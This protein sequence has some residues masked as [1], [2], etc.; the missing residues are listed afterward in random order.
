[1]QKASKAN[2]YHYNPKLKPY[3]RDNR[4]CMPKSAIRLWRHVLSNR[5]MLDYTFKRERPVL[6][7]I[8]DFMC[9]E[10]LLV[11]EVDGITHDDD[12]QHRRDQRRDKRLTEVG[13]RVVRYSSWEVLNDIDWVYQ[14]LRRIIDETVME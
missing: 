2:N 13:F 10:M 9:T 6:D 11:I 3:A 7:Y 14:D 4:K 12:N 8:A 5:Q 1:M